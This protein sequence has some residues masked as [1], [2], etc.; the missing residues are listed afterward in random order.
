MN[1]LNTDGR[2]ARAKQIFIA[3]VGSDRQGKNE[4]WLFGERSANRSVW[5]GELS[6]FMSP[7]GR[8]L[9]I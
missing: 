4:S 7:G 8:L 5:D 1:C 9:H 6:A 3:E 2:G